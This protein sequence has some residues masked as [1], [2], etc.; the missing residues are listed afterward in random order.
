M[1][2]DGGHPQVERAYVAK[3]QQDHRMLGLRRLWYGGV[4]GPWG[5][6]MD[7][8]YPEWTDRLWCRVRVKGMTLS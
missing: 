5:F 8:R 6:V 1:T 4:K 2:R 7:G 3:G